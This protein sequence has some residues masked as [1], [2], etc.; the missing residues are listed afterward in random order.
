MSKILDEAIFELEKDFYP[1][2]DGMVYVAKA[3]T[4]GNK[5]YPSYGNAVMVGGG[6]GSGKGY[7]ITQLFGIEGKRIDVDK[8]KDFA[9]E[10]KLVQERIKEKYGVDI[11][12]WTLDNP[13]QVSKLHEYLKGINLNDRYIK[14]V[15]ESAFL[16][17]SD[18]KPNLIF[19]KTLSS[20]SDFANL[21]ISLQQ[22]GYEKKN[23]HLVWVLNDYKMA[24]TQN[25]NRK[26]KVDES[27]LLSAHEE[28]AANMKR[29]ISFGDKIKQ[30]MDG[31]FWISFNQAKVDVE[32]EKSDFGGFYVKDAVYLK[33]KETGGSMMPYEKISLIFKQKIK[34]Y[35]PESVRYLWQ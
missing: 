11:S 5:N 15:K 20:F 29:I 27:I 25:R 8:L 35:I 34:S 1:E 7:Q 3:I 10:N 24:L 26:R 19:D 2:H 21:A 18:R 17:H 9:L 6:G 30:Y 12:G 31:D 23:I 14:M 16:S 28:T 33:I 22:I 32:I 4:F 13:K